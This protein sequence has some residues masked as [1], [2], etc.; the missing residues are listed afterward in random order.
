MWKHE[1]QNWVGGLSPLWQQFSEWSVSELSKWNCTV[2]RESSQFETIYIL[3]N[4]CE[5]DV[6][7][8]KWEQS[9]TLLR[10][11]PFQITKLFKMNMTSYKIFVLKNSYAIKLEVTLKTVQ[12]NYFKNPSNC[13][14]F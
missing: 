4:V 3:Y 1:N 2:Q 13:S 11:G 9:S 7:K 6:N 14:L 8:T 12:L 5:K 10:G